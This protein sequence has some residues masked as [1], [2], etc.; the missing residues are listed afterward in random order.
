MGAGTWRI[1]MI[2]KRTLEHAQQIYKELGLPHEEANS[3]ITIAYL[4][5]IADRLELMN[6]NILYVAALESM[7]SNH[8]VLKQHGISI[9]GSHLGVETPELL[10]ELIRSEVD[11]C[12]FCPE[13]VSSFVSLLKKHWG[14]HRSSS[15][16]DQGKPDDQR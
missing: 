8:P 9:L 3:I 4:M 11:A 2:E 12:L 16:D 13:D 15:P 10:F 7:K 14:E 5:I 6:Q 1:A